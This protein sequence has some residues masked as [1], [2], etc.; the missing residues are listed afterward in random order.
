MKYV[1]EIRKKKKKY[2]HENNN[3][4]PIDEVTNSQRLESHGK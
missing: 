1:I 4:T 3:S 2:V